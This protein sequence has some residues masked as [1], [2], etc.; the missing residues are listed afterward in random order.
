[1]GPKLAD[2]MHDS[3]GSYRLAFVT[4]R[5]HRTAA[6]VASALSRRP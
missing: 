4:A 6:S 5:V 2:S 1:V 3:T